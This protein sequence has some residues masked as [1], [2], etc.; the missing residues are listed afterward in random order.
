MAKLTISI[1]LLLLLLLPK[2]VPAASGGRSGGGSFQR[3]EPSRQSPPSR[4]SEPSRSRDSYSSPPYYQE[5]G[6]YTSSPSY[7][8][9]NSLSVIIFLLIV[10]VL[11]GGALIF[12]KSS[13]MSMGDS[14]GEMDEDNLPLPRDVKNERVTVSKIQ[15]ALYATARSVQSEIRQLS[16]SA[17][18]NSKEGLRHFL[19]ESLIILQ[20]NADAWCYALGDSQVYNRNTAIEKFDALST[21][22]RVKFSAETFSRVGNQKTVKNVFQNDAE[23]PEF[24]IVTL[25][26]GTEHD[27]PLFAPIKT[28]DDVRNALTACLGIT[29]TYLLTVELLWT[30][31]SDRD[32]LTKDD[33]LAKYTD[34]RPI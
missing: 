10:L 5:R 12:A 7:S 22:E 15:I 14:I 18:F 4:S 29:T 19:R 28:R 3:S 8:E 1:L 23:V 24:I 13:G 11:G 21:A 33:L 34:L 20:R 25:L 31:E 26:I 2:P 16:E 30:P 6:T 32:S 9:E 17:D 27:K